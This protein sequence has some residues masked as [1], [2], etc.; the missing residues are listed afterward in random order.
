MEKLR[1]T[2]AD[3]AKTLALMGA[4]LGLCLALPGENAGAYAPM[5]FLLAVFLTAR[6]TNG[7]LWGI[8]AACIGVLAVN[9]VFTYPYFQFNFTLAGYPVAVLCMLAV[10][11]VTSA[12]TTQNKRQETARIMAEKEKTRSNLLRAVSHD[13][14]TP[15]TG[16]LG[17]ATLLEEPGEMPE[18]VRR[19]LAREIRE[20]AGWLIRMVENLLTITRIDGDASAGITKTPEPAEEVLSSAAAKHRKR[21]REPELR[22]RVPQE[23]LMVP[24]DPVLIE[25][26][27]TNLLE[28]AAV[29]AQGATRMELRLFREGD[30]AV[31]EV[32]DNGCGLSPVQLHNVFSGFVQNRYAEDTDKRRGM[33]IG[34][35]VCYTIIRAHGGSLSARNAPNGGAIFRFSL[36]LGEE[37]AQDNKIKMQASET[38]GGQI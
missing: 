34:L 25:Q 32:E 11:V 23:L 2:V 26:V 3:L 28:N 8:G 36:P 18:A 7:Y 9:Y 21:Y 22:L 15:L 37:A 12:L 17:T 35:S 20:D 13:L 31:V 30:A 4:A 14:R 5:I 16:I 19:Q 33:G 1:R 27:I 38:P 24:M 6:S 29:H 10:S